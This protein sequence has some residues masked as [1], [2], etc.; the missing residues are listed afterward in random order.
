MSLNAV[1]KLAT[2]LSDN[3]NETDDVK[4]N[5][6]PDD[7]NSNYPLFINENPIK[8]T[9]TITLTKYTYATNSFVI[10]HPVYGELDSSVL[11]LDGGYDQLSITMPL[12]MPITLGVNSETL[13]STTF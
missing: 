7:L 5:I 4:R 3:I 13:Y 11:L 8:L 2:L 6:S 1:N 12:T 10:D 9:G